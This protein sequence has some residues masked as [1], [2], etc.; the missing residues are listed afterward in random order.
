MKYRTKPQRV[1]VLP[2]SKH[3]IKLFTM[4]NWDRNREKKESHENG[5]ENSEKYGNASFLPPRKFIYTCFRS[6]KKVEGVITRRR[7]TDIVE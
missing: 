2:A 5:G 4:T 1:M 3:A 6:S 7:Q